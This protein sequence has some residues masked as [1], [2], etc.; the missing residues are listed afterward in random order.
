MAMKDRLTGIDGVMDGLENSIPTH[1]GP[2]HPLQHHCSLLE[3]EGF[4][5]QS[6]LDDPFGI[7]PFGGFHWFLSTCGT[8]LRRE[9]LRR[10]LEP[11]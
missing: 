5:V 1:G 8:I 11:G 10:E 7:L 4:E 6:S 3:P 2:K 9:N